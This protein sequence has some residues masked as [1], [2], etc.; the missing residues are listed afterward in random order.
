MD[1]GDSLFFSVYNRS[2]E[3]ASATITVE[4]TGDILTLTSASPLNVNKAAG[5]NDVWLK[6][7]AEGKGTYIISLDDSENRYS[8]YL[9]ND[10]D[11]VNNG[12]WS[13]NSNNVLIVD[14]AQSESKY[15][16]ISGN[17]AE[18][19]YT[20]TLTKHDA[21]ELEGTVNRNIR[22]AKDETVLLKYTTYEARYTFGFNTPKNVSYVY[23]YGGSGNST[24]NA[25]TIN[26]NNECYLLLA[27]L[28]DD[29]TVN[30]TAQEYTY[31]EGNQIGYVSFDNSSETKTVN[32]SRNVSG[33]YAI[34]LP[35]GMRI[36]NSTISGLQEYG[37]GSTSYPCYTCNL[38]AGRTYSLTIASDYGSE[39]DVYASLLYRATLTMTLRS[40]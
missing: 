20:V 33:R 29:T 12:N 4:K 31:T 28:E 27:G 35:Y 16:R 11:A 22:L 36:T 6:A 30:I 2:E 25:W 18:D 19:T 8:L 40:M 26:P 1:E 5:Q 3:T 24:G 32:F 10:I 7:T 39:G 34:S 37:Q 15:V 14:F 23:S 9:Y 13:I 17:T 38:T 21:V